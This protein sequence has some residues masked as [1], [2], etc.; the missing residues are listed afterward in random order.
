MKWDFIE[1]FNYVYLY[2]IKL[3]QAPVLFLANKMLSLSIFK[4]L[5]EKTKWALKIV[6]VSETSIF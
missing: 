2:Y 3:T 1:L 6:N 4:F 5:K